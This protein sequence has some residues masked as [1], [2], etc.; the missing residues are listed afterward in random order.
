LITMMINLYYH[1]PHP[2]RSP[3]ATTDESNHDHTSGQP[4]PEAK[5]FK[6]DELVNMIDPILGSDDKNNPE[7][8]SAQQAAQASEKKA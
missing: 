4:V 1:P 6:D 8:V 5:I 2:I 3:H 7:F